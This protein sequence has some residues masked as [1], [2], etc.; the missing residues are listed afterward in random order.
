MG[1]FRV[2]FWGAIWGPL[3]AHLGSFWGP[4]GF[5]SC[6]L[7]PPGLA[8][9]I[10]CS[11]YA[12]RVISDFYSPAIPVNLKYEL[13]PALFVGWGGSA[14]LLLGGAAL[15]CSCGRGAGSGKG[16]YPRVNAAPRKTGTGSATDY[17]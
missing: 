12:H 3:G 10:A 13:G 8:A 6:P 5:I 1:P 7:W 11:W 2:H 16:R 9:L 14:L 17:V 4:F 15:L